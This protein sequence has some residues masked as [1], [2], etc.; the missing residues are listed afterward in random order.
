[1]RLAPHLRK[2]G[3]GGELVHKVA[4]QCL[5]QFRINNVVLGMAVDQVAAA[6]IKFDLGNFD[7]RGRARH[8]GDEGHADKTGKVG[9]GDSGAVEALT[10]GSKRPRDHLQCPGDL[11]ADG[12][13]CG[14]RDIDVPPAEGNVRS[15]GQLLNTA[16]C[17]ARLQAG[18]TRAAEDPLLELD[19]A[20][21]DKTGSD[22]DA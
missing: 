10:L 9:L 11:A 17:F 7:G 21:E 18:R 3:L 22:R 4:A 20:E 1:M 13:V 6:A 14:P 19:G 2:D 16:G 15:G 12:S 5:R 8:H